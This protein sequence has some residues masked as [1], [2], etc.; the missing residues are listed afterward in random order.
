[1]GP[2]VRAPP[3]P[4]MQDK[5]SRCPLIA[6]FRRCFDEVRAIFSLYLTA[7]C[8]AVRCCWSYPFFLGT[9]HAA[10]SNNNGCLCR[11]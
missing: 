5:T 11:M 7:G 9:R 8:W 3:P 2:R 4:R 10:R 6:P 1:M